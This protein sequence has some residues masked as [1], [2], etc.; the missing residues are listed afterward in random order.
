MHYLN[1]CD[2][3]YYLL[4]TCCIVGGYTPLDYA[5][6]NN[7]LRTVKL[8]LNHGA[9]VLRDNHVLVAKRKPILHFVTDPDVHKLL[10]TAV[11][12]QQGRMWC[13]VC[14]LLKPVVHPSSCCMNI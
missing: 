13:R 8:L 3:L 1:A 9:L 11:E 7:D 5:A 4:M 14:V 10:L 2:A 6:M 12:E